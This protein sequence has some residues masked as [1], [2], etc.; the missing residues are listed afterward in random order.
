MPLI[1]KLNILR[2]RIVSWSFYNI[3]FV[4]YLPEDR[5]KSGRNMYMCRFTKFV[6]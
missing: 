4:W 3:S 5:H 1:L 2:L 6:M